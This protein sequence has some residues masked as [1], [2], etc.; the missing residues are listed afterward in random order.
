MATPLGKDKHPSE[1]MASDKADPCNVDQMNIVGVKYEEISEGVHG[2]VA[3]VIGWCAPIQ[4]S[5]SECGTFMLQELP[6]E[7]SY[8]KTGTF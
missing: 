2:A 4:G 8:K 7:F 5:N 6:L 3:K 1:T